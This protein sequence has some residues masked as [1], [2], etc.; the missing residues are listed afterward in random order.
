MAWSMVA[1]GS[2]ATC[3]RAERGKEG[4]G[5]LP[6]AAMMATSKSQKEDKGGE[7]LIN[8]GW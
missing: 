8:E 2:P 3:S 1:R 4:N 6:L 5:T 7:G